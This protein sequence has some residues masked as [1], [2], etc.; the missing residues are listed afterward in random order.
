MTGTA[1]HLRAAWRTRAMTRLRM[2]R[3]IEIEDEA[4]AAQVVDYFTSLISK[5]AQPE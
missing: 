1:A 5:L 4:L 3:V 2:R